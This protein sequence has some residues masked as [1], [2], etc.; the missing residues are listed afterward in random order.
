MSTT[1]TIS[2]LKCR[3]RLKECVNW[4]QVMGNCGSGR[5]HNFW[6]RDRPSIQRIGK[7]GERKRTSRPITA[8]GYV[9][10]LTHPTPATLKLIMLTMATVGNPG[11]SGGHSFRGQSK[12]VLYLIN[13]AGFGKL[14]RLEER[15]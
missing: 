12:G 2:S 13:Y 9:Q 14:T 1:P 7:R 3:N 6:R 5:N 11:I 8:H 15:T 10:F 4:H